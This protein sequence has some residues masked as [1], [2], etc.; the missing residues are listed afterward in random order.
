LRHLR[1]DGELRAAR[2][3]AHL[4][5]VPDYLMPA[6]G[7]KGLTS[8]EIGFVGF[9]KTRE[10]RIRK[11]RENRAKGRGGRG[12]VKGRGL[13]VRGRGKVDPLK[14]FNAATRS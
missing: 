11:A 8:E 14:T 1:H 3:Q 12:G 13:G 5:H 10:N 2:I 4:K 6:K 7:K 9:R